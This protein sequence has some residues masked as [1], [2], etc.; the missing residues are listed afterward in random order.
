V[1]LPRLLD[2][3]RRGRF[4]F[5][6]LVR[7]YPFTDVNTAIADSLSGAV[8]KPVLTFD[9]YRYLTRQVKCLRSGKHPGG[10]A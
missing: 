5:D 9:L 4:P 3:Y 6:R 8:V 7:N 1:F 2:L 10:H